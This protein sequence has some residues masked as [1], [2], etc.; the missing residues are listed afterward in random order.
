MKKLTLEMEEL[1]VES[2]TTANEAASGDGTV[3]AQGA[4]P[5]VP[6][7]P[8]LNL[9]PTEQCPSDN[10]PTSNTTLCRC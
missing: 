6:S 3:Q 9:C 8:S 5:T 10:C 7:C 2:F 4:G 1:A